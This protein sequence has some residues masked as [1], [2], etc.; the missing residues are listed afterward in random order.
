M[1]TSIAGVFRITRQLGGTDMEC[2]LAAV[3]LVTLP[4]G[5]LE[6]SS[7][8]TD[9]VVAVLLIAFVKFRARGHH[10]YAATLPVG[11]GSSSCG[12]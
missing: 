2:C 7:V 4:I 1:A 11:Y 6:S 5:L 10:F 12:A 3:F 9:Y 8:Q